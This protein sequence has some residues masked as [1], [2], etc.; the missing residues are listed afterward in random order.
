MRRLRSFRPSDISPLEDRIA[1]SHTGASA[2]VAAAARVLTATF[3]G[4]YTTTTQFG[5]D[6]ESAVA[7]LTGTGRVPGVGIT[8]LSGSLSN[9]FVFPNR[10]FPTSGT[11]TVTAP[12]ATGGSMVVHVSGAYAN[13]SP[14]V[15]EAIHLTFTVTKATGKF[16]QYAGDHGQVTLTLVPTTP[17]ST[18]G[19]LSQT[20]VSHGHFRLVLAGA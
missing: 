5:V 2:E 15:P 14:T 4:P 10:G 13:L 20:H 7:H 19:G 17:V 12:T 3:Q 11:L 6:T 8:S 18:G 9:N 16:A 1:L